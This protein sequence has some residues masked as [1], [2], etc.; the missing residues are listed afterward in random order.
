MKVADSATV[1]ELSSQVDPRFG[2]A[3]YLRIID[4]DSRAIVEVIDNKEAAGMA[5]G[6]GIN[7]AGRVADAGAEAIITGVVGPKAAA[8]CE[9]AGIA[10]VNGA[11]G[12][13]AEAVEQF[14]ADP[15]ARAATPTRG[16]GA[17][18]PDE[19]GRGPGCRGGKGRNNGAGMGRGRCR[20]S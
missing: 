17:A 3:E 9:K 13:V 19:P 16:S 7:L 12:T 15:Q 1:A 4:T 10:M 18:V 5:Q 20:K 8:V 6:A 11:S 14:L 2:R